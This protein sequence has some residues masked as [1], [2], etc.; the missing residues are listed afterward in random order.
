MSNATVSIPLD[1][2][3]QMQTARKEAEVEAARLRQQLT[4]AKTEAS[5][6]AMMSATRAAIEIVRFA[7]AYLPAEDTKGWP[8]GALHQLAKALPQLPDATA[9]DNEL[10]TTLTSFSRECEEFERR[11][12]VISPQNKVASRVVVP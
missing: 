3:Q 8:T 5:D 9:D 2:F 10:A 7:V 1:E 11:R 12:Q 6:Q 4:T